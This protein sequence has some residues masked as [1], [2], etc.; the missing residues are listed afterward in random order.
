MR[1]KNLHIDSAD[2]TKL[3]RL[4]EEYEFLGFHYK[5]VSGHLTVFC[6]PKKK[7]QE[8]PTKKKR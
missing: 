7:K 8:K 5:L 3:R 6:L 4:A 2:D 1:V